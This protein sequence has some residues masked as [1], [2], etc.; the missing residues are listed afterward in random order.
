MTPLSNKKKNEDLPPL[1]VIEGS[2]F[3]CCATYI[4]ED[5]ANLDEK[6]KSIIDIVSNNNDKKNDKYNDNFNDD[7]ID[8]NKKSKKSIKKEIE[9]N[10]KE[11]YNKKST[12][13]KLKNI[14]K[15]LSKERS[16]EF[17]S[18]FS[19]ICC[20]KNICSKSGIEEEQQYNLIHTFSALSKNYDYNDVN[21]WII[22]NYDK[23][24]DN[25]GF[26]W[27]YL[28]NDC[29]KIDNIEYYEN[30]Y[31]KSYQE[32]KKV[33]EK[34]YFKCKKPIGFINLIIILMN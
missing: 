34:T 14:L 25:K 33:F 30:E 9:E 32:Q 15:A 5:F 4:K 19:L 28:I 11:E 26:A 22:K 20:I 13:L 23:L 18:W 17:N 3:D 1:N 6:F 27:P 12:F 29:L 16:T 7:N 21:E 31:L 2:I 8:D 10:E 24:N